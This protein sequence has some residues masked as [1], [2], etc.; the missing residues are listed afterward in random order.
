MNTILLTIDWRSNFDKH[1]L[2][3]DLV[4]RFIEQRHNDVVVK[5]DMFIN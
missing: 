1:Y 3:A 4:E 5:I 2:Y